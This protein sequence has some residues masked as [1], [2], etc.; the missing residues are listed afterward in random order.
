MVTKMTKEEQECYSELL[1]SVKL[2]VKIDSYSKIS[3]ALERLEQF[4][5]IM[6]IKETKAVPL[7][8]YEIL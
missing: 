8:E 3:S 5:I 7:E 2:S 1:T 6:N 4:V